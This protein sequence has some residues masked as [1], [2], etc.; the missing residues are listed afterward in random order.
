LL[1]AGAPASFELET[2]AETDRDLIARFALTIIREDGF[3]ATRLIS[4]YITW[5]G[6]SGKTTTVV[7]SMENVQLGGARYVVTAQI[8]KSF[9][10]ERPENAVNY[11]LVPRCFEFRVLP[12]S[13]SDVS[14]FHQKHNWALSSN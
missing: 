4:D 6:A 7:A 5:K 1:Q 8:L 9:D 13:A 14:L 11:D 2:I 3:V 10:L 12:F